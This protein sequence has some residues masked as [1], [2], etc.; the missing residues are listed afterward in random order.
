MALGAACC[1]PDTVLTGGFSKLQGG[2]CLFELGEWPF[3]DLA[4]ARQPPNMPIHLSMGSQAAGT[5]LKSEH[6]VVSMLAAP[7]AIA[8][9]PHLG[10][11]LTLPVDAIAH[12][13]SSSLADFP[14]Q[15]EEVQ[16]LPIEHRIWEV[17]SVDLCMLALLHHDM[18]CSD[19]SNNVQHRTMLHHQQG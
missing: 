1:A 15:V 6:S 16:P 19:L 7:V 14:V 3:L 9:V 4:L 13:P 11:D 8:E 17:V 18:T 12:F 10:K 2:T 5:A